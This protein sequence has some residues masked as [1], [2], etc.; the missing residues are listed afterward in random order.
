MGTYL[1]QGI[2]R[3]DHHRLFAISGYA[4]QEVRQRPLDS[5][6]QDHRNDWTGRKILQAQ[7]QHSHRGSGAD[8]AGELAFWTSIAI[9]SQRGTGRERVTKAPKTT[10]KMNSAC[11]MRAATAS[12]E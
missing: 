3:R 10:H 2:A 12:A 11:R 5:G 4:T 9:C 1:F 7:Y 6:R 8:Q